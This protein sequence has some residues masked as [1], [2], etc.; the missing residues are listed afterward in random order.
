[1]TPPLTTIE[2]P[3]EKMGERAADFLVRQL[4][5]D[6][7]LEFIELEANLILRGTTWPPPEV[8]GKK[9]SPA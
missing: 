4:T 3:A 7:P 1:M 2:V 6:R 5:G 9:V 8:G